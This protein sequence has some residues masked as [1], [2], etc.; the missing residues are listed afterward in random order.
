MGLTQDNIILFPKWREMLEEESLQALKEKRYGTA[1]KKL[2]KLIEHKVEDVEIFTG[3]LICLMELGC[4][5]RPSSHVKSCWRLKTK[6]ICITSIS[7]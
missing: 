5:R 7:T 2:N 3:K 6:I 1:L 4:L